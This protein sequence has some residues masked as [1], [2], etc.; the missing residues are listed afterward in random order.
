MSDANRTIVF[1]AISNMLDNPDPYGIYPTTECYD[2]LEA[3]LDAKDKVIVFAAGL[4]SATEHFSSW[5]PEH[6]LKYLTLQTKDPGYHI[7]DSGQPT[8]GDD[9]ERGVWYSVA[10]GYWTDNWNRLDTVQGVIPCCPY[11]RCPGYQIAAK[12]WFDIRP[13][14]LE[15]F[16]CYD[17]WLPTSRELCRSVDGIEFLDRFRIQSNQNPS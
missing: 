8:T 2:T 5:H 6:V 14:W 1:K 7:L 11:C 15:K 3:A 16:P 10:C 17:V 4:L 12:Q 13:E 9:P